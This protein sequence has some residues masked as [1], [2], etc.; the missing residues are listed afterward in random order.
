VQPVVDM[1]RPVLPEIDTTGVQFLSAKDAASAKVKINAI[2]RSGEELNWFNLINI[3]GCKHLAH[4]YLTLPEIKEH[5]ID[6]MIVS[7][8]PVAY[9]NG[10]KIVGEG[11]VLKNNSIIMKLVNREVFAHANFNLQRS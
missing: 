4:L 8:S 3:L 11:F 2:I 5:L 10:E 6:A 7:D 1:I 9:I